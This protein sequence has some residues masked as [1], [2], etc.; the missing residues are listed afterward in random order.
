M[1][2]S[3]AGDPTI[4]DMP[5]P[6]RT[7]P[8]VDLRFG[9]A[10]DFP[11]VHWQARCVEALA[12]VPGV[13]L[14][15]WVQVSPGRPRRGIA[16]GSSALAIVPMPDI[17]RRLE[18]DEPKR[19]GSADPDG[20]GNVDVLLDVSGRGVPPPVSWASEVW[21]FRYGEGMHEDPVRAAL[22]DYV[23]TPGRTRVALVAEPG[24]LI[25][26]KAGC[27]GGAASNSTGSC[28]IPP[29]G[30]PQRRSTELIRKSEN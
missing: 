1:T 4:P 22:I 18:V 15:R 27:P 12:E 19:D 8:V 14:V 25:V 24:R 9:V 20:D 21:R 26:G 11:V 16:S 5:K 17:L 3:A 7:I 28:W 6:S 10:T 2:N 13:A 29:A 23:R 30:L